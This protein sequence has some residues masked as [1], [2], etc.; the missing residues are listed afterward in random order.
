LNFTILL[1][2]AYGIGRS[3]SV[4]FSYHT[5][6]EKNVR[7]PEA[8]GVGHDADNLETYSHIELVRMFPQVPNVSN[9]ARNVS[10][11]VD[12]AQTGLVVF[13]VTPCPESNRPFR[14]YDIFEVP[15]QCSADTLTPV[16]RRYNKWMDFPRRPTRRL[17]RG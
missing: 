10:V 15:N 17:R 9:G 3:S 11:K 8:V 14:A 1:I 2:R 7:L 16:L 13:V 4:Q 6:G 5:L 12:D